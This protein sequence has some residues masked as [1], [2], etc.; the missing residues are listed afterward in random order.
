LEKTVEEFLI[1][2]PL[3]AAKELQDSN[4]NA[5]ALT[6]QKKQVQQWFEQ[7]SE[8]SRHHLQWMKY[9]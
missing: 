2:Y 1:T 9:F 4:Y 7:L 8:K 3:S 5:R 6:K